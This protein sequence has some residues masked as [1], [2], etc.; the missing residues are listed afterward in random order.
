MSGERVWGG[1]GGLRVGGGF[2]VGGGGLRVEEGEEEELE[3]EEEEEDYFF[4]YS[5]ENFI[6][7]QKT[8][9]IQI[10]K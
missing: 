2:G 10:Y 6:Y 1:R 8:T 5:K 7:N 4:D 9:T 3:E